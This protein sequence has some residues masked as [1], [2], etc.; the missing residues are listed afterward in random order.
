MVETDGALLLALK[1]PQEHI[2]VRGDSGFTP[3]SIAPL[4][5]LP[6]TTVEAA[7]NEDDL[8]PPPEDG[9][10]GTKI[11]RANFNLDAFA[12]DLPIAEAPEVFPR[13]H[14]VPDYDRPLLLRFPLHFE[15]GE[16]VAKG[17]ETVTPDSDTATGIGETP[18]SVVVPKD[19]AA[20]DITAFLVDSDPAGVAV[21]AGPDRKAVTI[22]TLPGADPANPDSFGAELSIVGAKGGWFLIE[23]ATHPAELFGVSDTETTAPLGT[24]TEFQRTAYRGR[25][26]VHGS[27][28]SLTIQSGTALRAAADPASKPVFDL[29]LS[30]DGESYATVTGLKSCKGDALELNV[31]RS[32]GKTG[33]GWIG[34]GDDSRLCAAQAEECS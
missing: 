33:S 18:A 4:Y 23:N 10:D 34:G 19:I 11:Y 32:D 7:L 5:N 3:I 22:A 9:D 1:T 17:G 24:G 29:Q 30:D 31:T 14:V 25:G 15:K 8:P 16:L 20:C 26:W 6:A 12:M 21:H 28:L 2:W 13:T 27:R